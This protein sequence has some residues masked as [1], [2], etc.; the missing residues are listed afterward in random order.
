MLL[1]RNLLIFTVLLLRNSPLWAE[2]LSGRVTDGAEP[3][4]K[5]EVTLIGAADNVIVGTAQTDTDGKYRLSAVTG[6][7]KLRASKAEFADVWV[8]DISFSG[9]DLTVNITMTPA[10]FEDETY[11]APSDGCD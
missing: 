4:G 6:R 2:T 3:I 7:Y 8:R 11:V 1:F 5:V 9:E 10:V